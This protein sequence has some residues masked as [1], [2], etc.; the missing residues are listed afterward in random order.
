MRLLLTSLHVGMNGYQSHSVASLFLISH[1]F[2]PRENLFTAVVSFEPNGLYVH[3]SLHLSLQRANHSF[4]AYTDYGMKNTMHTSSARCPK[5][6]ICLI[7]SSILE[8]HY[9]DSLYTRDL[10]GC[11]ATSHVSLPKNEGIASLRLTVWKPRLSDT[12]LPQGSPH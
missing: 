5:A 6:T 9:N 1:L 12:I 7:F 8:Y 10:S 2:A 3:I 4:I 11:R